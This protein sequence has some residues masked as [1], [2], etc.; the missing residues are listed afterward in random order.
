M[1]S[2]F[3]GNICLTLIQTFHPPRLAGLRMQ[4]NPRQ[5]KGSNEERLQQ[6]A[7]S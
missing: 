5:P 6:I 4:E 1:L 7:Y 2:S 3:L